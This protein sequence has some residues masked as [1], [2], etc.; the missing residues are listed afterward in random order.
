MPSV[1]YIQSAWT[2]GQVSE[3]LS[4]RFDTDILPKSASQLQNMV[5]MQQGGL[6]KR[7]GTEFT[8]LLS[9][10]LDVTNG[11]LIPLSFNNENYILVLLQHGELIVKNLADF[12]TSFTAVFRDL[13]LSKVRYA[14]NGRELIIVDG[15]GVP[16]LLNIDDTGHPT[17]S[18]FIFTVGISPSY[19]YNRKP[20]NDYFF[21]LDSESHTPFQ[22]GDTILIRPYDTLAHADA[23]GNNKADG[24]IEFSNHYIGGTFVA[25]GST[26]LIKEFR[27]SGG[28][29]NF[30]FGELLENGL[31]DQLSNGKVFRGSSVFLG[32]PLFSDERGYPNSV[33]IYQ[34]RLYFGG[35][36]QVTNI[37]VGSA[38]DKFTIFESGTANESDPI[39]FQLSSD[40]TPTIKHI[41]CSKTLVI[42][43][44][45]AEF[46][47][48]NN[49]QAVTA[50][51]FNVVLQTKNGSDD[52]IPQ[53]TDDQL[54]Y[55]QAGG[56]VIRATDYSYSV[57]SY[58]SINV[59]ILCPEIIN[60][61][62]DACLMRNLGDDDN[63]YLLFV[64]SDGT[65]A[66]LQIIQAQNISAWSLWTSLDRKFLSLCTINNRT[67]ALVENTKN[68]TNTKYTLEE[69]K[70]D[71][72]MDCQSQVTV[73]GGAFN[74]GISHTNLS[75]LMNNG[76]LK[77]FK[78][79]N[80][81]NLYNVG[82]ATISGAGI[83]GT[84]IICQMTTST[85]S[86]HNDSIGDITM[87]Q[88][89]LTEIFVKYYKTLGLI[90]IIND[91][92]ND[93]EY[94]I[95][96][97]QY[98]KDNYDQTLVPKTDIYRFDFPVTNSVLEPKIGFKQTTPYPVSILAIACTINFDI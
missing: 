45:I 31:I 93:V 92:E 89:R 33:G 64:N 87:T 26:I 97:I 68:S 70:I 48:Q 79:T 10:L 8:A 76:Y 88:K 54:F 18:S 57:N 55:V 36:K 46:A 98:D 29:C 59:S 5:V 61:P 83:A 62:A 49:N 91:G 19:D 73:A 94:P 69:F 47:L 60:Q 78:N 50:T 20:Y 84:D 95:K 9:G 67:F 16:L 7:P 51:N 42:L 14:Q 6:T 32:E 52:C 15:E 53:E 96:S 58:A 65:I 77:Q 41:V 72:Y 27:G 44:D 34:G 80:A 71:A 2:K 23:G 56:R 74:S 63:S 66:C 90:G 22:I 85:I 21:R 38:V 35:N 37:V 1:R 40:I 24:A 75:L 3:K 30:L 81:Q 86:L 4:T 39:S 13:N 11:I 25:G 12:S 17:D 43:T 28:D 82:D